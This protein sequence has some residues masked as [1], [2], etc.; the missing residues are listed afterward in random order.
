MSEI[1]Q[2][3]R[4]NA[5]AWAWA[6]G[7][8]EREGAELEH[9]G[10]EGRRAR[11]MRM[12]ARENRVSRRCLARVW[13]VFVASGIVSLSLSG[14]SQQEPSLPSGL[15]FDESSA[16]RFIGAANNIDHV[17]ILVPTA[18]QRNYVDDYAVE[19]D[20]VFGDLKSVDPSQSTSHLFFVLRAKSRAVM[21]YG[22]YGEWQKALMSMGVTL[23]EDDARWR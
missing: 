20:L 7:R 11:R 17:E 1:N 12:M 6:A 21:E 19:G 10:R 2:G 5:P 13:L 23:N 8:T 22:T 16:G 18:F 14:C 9:K 15:V 3:K 4:P